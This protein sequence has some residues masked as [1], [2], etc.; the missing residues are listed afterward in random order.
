MHG[1]PPPPKRETGNVRLMKHSGAFVQPLLRWKSNEYYKT[2][3]C[4]FVAFG[5]QHAM[6]VRH[7]VIRGLAPLYNVFPRFLIN[8]TI[9]GGGGKVSEHKM[10]VIIFSTTS[11]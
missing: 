10:S 4:V 3:V 6:R 1:L 11:V 2:R 7:I 8:S 5:T 9:F